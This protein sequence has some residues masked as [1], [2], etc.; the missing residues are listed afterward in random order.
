MSNKKV[1]LLMVLTTIATLVISITAM[2]VIF[3]VSF[4]HYKTS[5]EQAIVKAERAV[6]ESTNK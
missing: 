2:A 1:V 5:Y 4:E 6:L 3:T